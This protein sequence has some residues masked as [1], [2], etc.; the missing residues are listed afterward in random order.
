MRE[1][2]SGQRQH[3]RRL[4]HDIRPVVQ[5]GKQGVTDNAVATVDQ[6]L[7]AHELIKIKF[8][9]YQD[10]RHALSADLATSLGAA[11]VGVVGNVAI[12]YRRQ[13]DPERRKIELS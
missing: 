7:D 12:M 11:L 3:L 8:L 13:R 9:D 10:Q 6:A 4:A 5:I 2:T 1:L